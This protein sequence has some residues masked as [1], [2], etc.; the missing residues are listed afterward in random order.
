M[1]LPESTSGRLPQQSLCSA[2]E[3]G[4]VGA[5]VV[6]AAVNH[7]NPG[8]GE[9]T[10]GVGMVVATSA[11]SGVDVC[12]PRALVAAVVGEGGQCPAEAFV[13]GPAEMHGLLFAGG[14]S[15][16]CRSGECG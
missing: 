8:A 11:G 16:R 14:F 7:P 2:V 15:H 10:H 1:T 13:A 9:D 5:V 12:G 3:V 6:P 4:V